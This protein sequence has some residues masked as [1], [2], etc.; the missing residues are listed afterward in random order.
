MD[1]N[2]GGTDRTGLIAV[3]S[4]GQIVREA[5]AGAQIQI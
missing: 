2:R 1:Y 4:A 3:R 5:L